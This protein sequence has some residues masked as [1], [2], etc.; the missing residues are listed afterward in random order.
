[1][2]AGLDRADELEIV[3]MAEEQIQALPHDR[4]IVDAKAASP[5]VHWRDVNAIGTPQAMERPYDA[6]DVHFDSGRDGRFG[7]REGGGASGHRAG[8]VAVSPA[9]RG[10][11][12]RAGSRGPAAPG[13]PECA[14]RPG[15]VDQ[16]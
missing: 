10:E 13:A 7:H 9:Q 11:R 2:F 14:R 15:V 1:L 4:M 12:L 6:R 5:S 16:P 8:E 3:E